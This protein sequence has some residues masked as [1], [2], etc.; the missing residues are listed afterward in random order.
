MRKRWYRDIG[1]PGKRSCND[2]DR[3]DSVHVLTRTAIDAVMRQAVPSSAALAADPLRWRGAVHGLLVAASLA[4]HDPASFVVLEAARFRALDL[5]AMAHDH[6]YPSLGHVLPSD[7]VRGVC[8]RSPTKVKVSR[9]SPYSPLGTSEQYAV[10]AM[11]ARGVSIPEV[12]AYVGDAPETIMGTYAHFIRESESMAK[13]ALDLAL[14][15]LPV[16]SDR[17]TTA[18]RGQIRRV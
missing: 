6:A 12:A 5:V 16:A 7:L 17:D 9:P 4:T 1:L 10:S 2:Q 15:P 18:T 3:A 11:L 8:A 13:R 14:S